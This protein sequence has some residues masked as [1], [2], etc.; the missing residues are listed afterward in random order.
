MSGSSGLG[1]S[2]VPPWPAKPRSHGPS[3][4]H[5]VTVPTQRVKP[6]P[7][8]RG[9][10]YS[11]RPQNDVTNA[12]TAPAPLECDWNVSGGVGQ[13]VSPKIIC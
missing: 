9:G 5:C 11:G 7:S 6:S 10:A 12:G 13:T 2:I 3:T 8:G 4:G 1:S